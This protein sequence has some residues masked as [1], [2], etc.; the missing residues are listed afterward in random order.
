MAW[1]SI[2]ANKPRAF[3]TM[4]GIIIGVASLV[5][6]V[7]LVNSATSAV[8]SE[9][10][11]MGKDLFTATVRDDKGKPLKLGDLEE[12]AALEDIALVAPTN[13]SS[14]T[15]K[16]GTDTYSVTVT[17]TTNAY[18]HIMGYELAQ[19]RFLLA[20]DQKNIS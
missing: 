12:F 20:A 11:S 6:L 5:V 8:T 14:A 3:L 1:K 9:I 10:A 7:S 15:A 4:L 2:C 18:F 13:S 19:G 17:G 16:Q